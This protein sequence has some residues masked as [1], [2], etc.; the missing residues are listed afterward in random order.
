ME[1]ESYKLK[2]DRHLERMLKK[3]EFQEG[4]SSIIK[5]GVRNN[6]LKVMQEKGERPYPKLRRGGG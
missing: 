6:G 4:I 1:I 2:V 3:T 5:H